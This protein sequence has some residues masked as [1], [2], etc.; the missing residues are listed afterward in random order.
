MLL[1]QKMPKK[2]RPVVYMVLNACHGFLFGTMY[3]PAQA[4]LFGMSFKAMIAWIVAGLPWD[5]IHGVSNFF[6]GIL[7]VPIVN[8]LLRLENNEY[9]N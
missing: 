3:A 1:P 8:V 2:I 7:I 4:L 9:R 6:S 5:M